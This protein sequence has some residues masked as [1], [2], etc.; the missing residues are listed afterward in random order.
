MSEGQTSPPWAVLLCPET[1]RETAGGSSV[2]HPDVFR[3]ASS[4]GSMSEEERSKILHD[5]VFQWYSNEGGGYRTEGI[6]TSLRLEGK[7]DGAR[8]VHV[9]KVHAVS[10]LSAFIDTLVTRNLCPSFLFS[11]IASY[12]PTRKHRKLTSNGRGKYAQTIGDNGIGTEEQLVP[13]P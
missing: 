7:V 10:G 11:H 1:C 12:P 6:P 2:L 3:R 4:G 13:F 9:I 8:V 5:Y